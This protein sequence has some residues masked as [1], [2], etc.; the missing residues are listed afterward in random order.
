MKRIVL[1]V[2]AVLVLALASPAVAQQP[3]LSDRATATTTAD[4][5]DV[6]SPDGPC[7]ASTASSY[8]TTEPVGGSYPSCRMWSGR[9][10]PFRKPT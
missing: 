1:G 10:L 5:K 8:S 2:N 6:S 3:S 7:A 9:I 4:R